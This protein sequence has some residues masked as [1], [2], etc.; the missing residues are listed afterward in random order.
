MKTH[1]TPIN[2]RHPSKRPETQRNHLGGQRGPPENGGKADKI[3]GF[4]W[5]SG[6]YGNLVKYG[7]FWYFCVF[8]S[9]MFPHLFPHTKCFTKNLKF[10]DNNCNNI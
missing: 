6:N 8:V 7:L 9:P 2:T 10:D 3:K 4:A 1:Q 5:V